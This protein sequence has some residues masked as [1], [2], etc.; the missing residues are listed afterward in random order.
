MTMMVT[1]EMKLR[2]CKRN[3]IKISQELLY[4]DDVLARIRKANTENEIVRIML[5]ARRE[6]V[7]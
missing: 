1:S 4:D 6:C 3:A 2:N 7:L 5:T